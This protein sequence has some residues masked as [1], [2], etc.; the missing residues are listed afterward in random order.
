MTVSFGVFFSRATIFFASSNGQA[1]DCSATAFSSC[2]ISGAGIDIHKL[3]RAHIGKPPRRVK[4]EAFTRRPAPLHAGLQ[5]SES[6]ARSKTAAVIGGGPAGLI[7][8][9][10]LARAGV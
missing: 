5:M 8:A 10:T 1:F 6:A 2:A 9:E 3:R 7:A 4:S